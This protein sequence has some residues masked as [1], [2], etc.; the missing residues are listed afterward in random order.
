MTKCDF[1][2]KSSPDGKCYWT[3]QAYREG[4]CKKAIKLMVEALKNNNNKK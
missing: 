2:I 1:C 4:D 3:I